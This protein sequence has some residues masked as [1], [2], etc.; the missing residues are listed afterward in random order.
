MSKLNVTNARRKTRVR[1]ALRRTANGRPRLSIFRSSK[2]IYAQVIDDL[3]GETLASASSLEKTLREAGNT[4][5]NIDAAKAVG[6]L[7]AERAV[8]QGVKEVVF[9]RGGYLYHGRVKA[10]ADAAREGGLSF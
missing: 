10:L 3:K 1:I 7:V 6:K 9:D 4:G 5:A 8:K 2:H